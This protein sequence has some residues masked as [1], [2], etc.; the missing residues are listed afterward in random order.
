MT[1]QSND[2]TTDLHLKYDD[3]PPS[4]HL[5]TTTELHLK[6]DVF[7][8]SSTPEKRVQHPLVL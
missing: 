6:H 4:P 2:E 8:G 3:F 7:P 1:A 5:K